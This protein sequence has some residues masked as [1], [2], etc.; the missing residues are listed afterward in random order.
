MRTSIRVVAL[1]ILVAALGLTYNEYAY[2]MDVL[3][4]M[5]TG[6]AAFVNLADGVIGNSRYH[7]DLVTFP[8]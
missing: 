7:F 2:Y 5:G 1:G 3:Q 8:T 6:F 4:D